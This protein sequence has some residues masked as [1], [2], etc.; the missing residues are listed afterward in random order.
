[1]TMLLGVWMAAGVTVAEDVEGSETQ[2]AARS[3]RYR[4]QPT[5]ELEIIFRFTPEFNQKVQVQ[6][7]GFVALMDTG[8]LEVAGR[9][10]ESVRGLIAEKYSTILNNPVVTVRLINF[11]KPQFIV[12]GEVTK[13]GRYELAG[14]LTLSDAIAVAGGFTVRARESEVLLFRRFSRDLVEV[15][16]VNVKDAQKG[17][18]GEDVRVR[19]GDSVFVPRSTVGEID[20]YLSITRL[21]LY[22]PLPFSK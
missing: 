9:T 11:T 13:P 15:K 5:D 18:F 22:F 10:L 7:D 17:R 19:A 20:R 3:P 21:G 1:M 12:G 16:K 14:E 8:D 2:F 4:L 6:P